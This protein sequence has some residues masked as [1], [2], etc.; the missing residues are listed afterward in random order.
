MNGY[1]FYKDLTY[2]SRKHF[3]NAKNVGFIDVRKGSYTIGKVSN[4]FIE[5][6]KI[7]IKFATVGFDLNGEKIKYNFNEDKATNDICKVEIDG[8][9]ITLGYSE[10]RVLSSNG[11]VYASPDKI[12]YYVEKFSYL[13]PNEFIEA[14]ENR[15]N[16]LDYTLKNINEKWLGYVSNYNKFY[17]LNVDYYNSAENLK[18]LIKE[19]KDKF[20]N[21]IKLQR[22]L[23]IITKEGSLLNYTIKENEPEL[24]EYLIDHNININKFSGI[25][26]LTAIE[27]NMNDIVKLLI[28]NGI[29]VKNYSPRVNPLFCA[30]KCNNITA[31]ELLIGDKRLN[32]VYKYLEDINIYEYENCIGSSENAI[33][34][35]KGKIKEIDALEYAKSLQISDEIINI[36]KVKKVLNF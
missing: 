17:T 11:Q 35:Y 4:K 36:L 34:N 15:V 12:Y 13:P 16:I 3:E 29:E 32:I 21:E 1:E 6:L 5:N 14:V 27:K 2:Y 20:K 10:I 30:I 25:E 9:E 28:E 26:L 31:V 18:N 33:L 19:N 7:Y 22:N 8:Q 24:V 23:E